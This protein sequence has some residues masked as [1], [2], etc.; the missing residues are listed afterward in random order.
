LRRGQILDDEEPTRLPGGRLELR[1]HDF[2]GTMGQPAPLLVHVRDIGQP[3]FA[4]AQQHA[5]DDGDRLLVVML[6][7]R[8]LD[9]G[10]L[11]LVLR[12]GPFLL[13][14]RQ[15]PE[16]AA[17]P[18]QEYERQGGRQAGDVRLAPAPANQAFHRAHRPGQHRPRQDVGLPG[19][20]VPQQ[21]G[22]G[23]LIA[24]GLE[25][26]V[27]AHE[28]TRDQAIDL[29]HR[30][31]RAIR[32][33]DETGYV[34]V[35]DLGTGNV[36]MHG[37]NSALEGKPSSAMD[38]LRDA[39][40]TSDV[41]TTSYMFPRPGK[42][43][44]LRKVVAVVKFP[45]WNVVIYT[46]AYTD[47]LDASFNA[48]MLRLGAIGGTVLLLTML[49]AWLVNRDMA[50]W[51]IVIAAIWQSSGFAMALFL[52][53]LRS[54]D[55]DII[56]AC[57]LKF[58]NI[59]DAPKFDYDSESL[60]PGEKSVLEAIAKCLT[61]GPLKGRAVDLVGR[62]DPRGDTEDHLAPRLLHFSSGGQR[63]EQRDTGDHNRR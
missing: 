44:P 52:A 14:A 35:T 27:V 63:R 28:I 51:T 59:E 45:P 56:K 12:L 23:E 30:N 41:G 5:I 8:P 26:R 10:Q 38:V 40:R 15:L 3:G 17:E 2:Q 58:E 25:A 20:G 49:A 50:I 18:G 16:H 61:T 36:L 43:E 31:V 42:T 4:D 54:V 39:V 57:N 62:A 47:D 34:A 37:V 48:S 53:G 6:S 22:G 32:F 11:A 19:L 29:F 9:I 13:D 24:A 33:D 46:G 55:A 7:A 1:L 60:T 21:L